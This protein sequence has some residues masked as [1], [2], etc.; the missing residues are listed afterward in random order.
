MSAAQYLVNPAADRGSTTANS[1]SAGDST[2][3]R[4]RRYPYQLTPAL[5]TPSAAIITNQSTSVIAKKLAAGADIPAAP[6]GPERTSEQPDPSGPRTADA[7]PAT[8]VLPPPGHPGNMRHRKPM[9]L[10]H[11]TIECKIFPL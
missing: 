10:I 1:K 8:V 3:R 2:R 4:Q 11:H 6:D 7:L 9:R 5:A